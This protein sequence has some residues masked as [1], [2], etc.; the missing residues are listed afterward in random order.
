M[1]SAS[2]DDES[3]G[4]YSY[5]SDR[6][7]AFEE[8]MEALRRAC[9]IAGTDPNDALRVPSGLEDGDD[10][11]GGGGSNV[12]D[13]AD[14]LELANS[15]RRRFSAQASSSSSFDRPPIV[16]PLCTLLPSDLDEDDD[17]EM[18]RTIQRRFL[19][20]ESGVYEN[21]EEVL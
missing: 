2:Y 16:R 13:G 3:D 1:A 11:S 21:Y 17:F 14:D 10:G 12:D 9:M 8:D 15:I 19:Q 7:E 6:D 20:Y 5:G 18:L 4:D